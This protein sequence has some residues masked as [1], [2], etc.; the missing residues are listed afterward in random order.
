MT[1]APNETS[2][3]DFLVVSATAFSGVGAA[4]ALWPFVRQLAP[5]AATL[6]LA[7]IEVDLAPIAQGQAAT[8]MWRGKPVFVRHRTPAEIEAARAVP[9]KALADPRARND[10][11]DDDAPAT[12]ANRIK[13]EHPEWLVVVG[14]C[15]HLGCVPQGQTRLQKRGDYG[16]WFCSCHGSQYDTSGRIRQGPAPANLEV[17]P[18]YFISDTRILIGQAKAPATV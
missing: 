16:G 14:I 7:N 2:R 5:D 11:I 6:A 15:T 17:P 13:R 8:V 12:D 18:Y 3:R 1:T 9:V 10:A 4:L